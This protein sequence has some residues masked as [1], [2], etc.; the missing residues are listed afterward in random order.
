MANPRGNPQNLIPLK[1]GYD[2]KRLNSG[3]KKKPP[4]I[5]DLLMKVLGEE[6]NGVDGLT[7][8]VMAL[9]NE[10]ITGRGASKARAAELILE[11]LYGKP[12][13]TVETKNVHRIEV[14]RTMRIAPEDD[15]D[16]E[17]D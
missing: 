8:I 3:R 14:V 13:E 7:A 12:K 6:K 4:P 1:K 2:P 17:D 16:I 9:R 10:A 15:P 5:H 11:R